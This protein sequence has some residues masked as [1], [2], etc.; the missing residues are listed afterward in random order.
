MRESGR[1]E[2][3]PARAASTGQEGKRN[4]RG[5]RAWSP[6]RSSR[7]CL[8]QTK[9]LLGWEPGLARR[10]DRFVRAGLRDRGQRR[11]RLLGRGG[12]DRPRAPGSRRCSP[13][14]L[15]PGCRFSALDS[16]P[17]CPSG[18]LGSALHRSRSP[19]LG[20]A[21]YLPM[22]LVL[23]RPFAGLPRSPARSFRRREL[24]A[25]LD[26]PPPQIAALGFTQGPWLVGIRTI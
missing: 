26:W 9:R 4:R 25:R 6:L 13:Y 20:H 5:P 2:S 17:L 3:P 11:F 21:R 18:G 22:S 10:W 16:P 12:C 15:A 14:C 8:G 23:T 1:K 24:S 19:L 7:S